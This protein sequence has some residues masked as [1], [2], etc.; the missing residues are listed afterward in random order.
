MQT[1][2]LS[3][4]GS[5][6]GQDWE[7][8][9]RVGLHSWHVTYLQK[10]KDLVLVAECDGSLMQV[11]VFNPSTAEF[12]TTPGGCVNPLTAEFETKRKRYII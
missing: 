5:Y 6:R 8:S 11:S 2:L 7:A 10:L 3:L 12:E 1:A 9:A 4:G